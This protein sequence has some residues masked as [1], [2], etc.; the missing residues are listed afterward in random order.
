MSRLPAVPLPTPH[1]L[2]PGVLSVVAALAGSL[3][4]LFLVAP[5]APVWP[6]VV[7]GLALLV[8]VVVEGALPVPAGVSHP[9]EANG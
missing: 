4:L 2:L 7:V 1:S 9:A 8:L 6:L 5:L 3:L